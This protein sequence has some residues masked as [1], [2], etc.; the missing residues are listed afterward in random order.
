MDRLYLKELHLVNSGPGF[1]VVHARSFAKIHVESLIITGFD[2]RG[3]G[4]LMKRR[5]QLTDC[6]RDISMEEIQRFYICRIGLYRCRLALTPLQAMSWRFA[7]FLGVV[8]AALLV[9]GYLYCTL[10]SP[11][12]GFSLFCLYLLMAVVAIVLA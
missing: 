6:I 7:A 4:C 5:G 3:A 1:P 10:P 2:V 9:I 11:T 12:K 8:F